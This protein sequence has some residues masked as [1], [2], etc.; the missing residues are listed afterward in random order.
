M[1]GDLKKVWAALLFSQVA[2]AFLFVS[3]LVV[4]LRNQ[5]PEEPLTSSVGKQGP[6][7]TVDYQKVEQIIEEEVSALPL[8]TNGKNGEDGKDGQDGAPGKDG[9]P[10]A[11]GEDGHTPVKGVDYFD[12]EPGL[13]GL[14]AQ[15]AEFRVNSLTNDVE[16][17]C[18]GDTLWTTLASNPLLSGSCI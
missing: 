14:N 16:W 4:A 8:P 11:P 7:G 17:R 13:P 6:P 3:V 1:I 15:Q 2:V 9:A 5:P 12:G 10:G 18:T